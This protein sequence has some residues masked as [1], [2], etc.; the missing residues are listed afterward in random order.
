MVQKVY[1][2]FERGESRTSE[3]DMALEERGLQHDARCDFR[4]CI[5]R[6][7]SVFHGCNFLMGHCSN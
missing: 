5:F 3:G 7:L 6:V 1:L 2:L 4:N